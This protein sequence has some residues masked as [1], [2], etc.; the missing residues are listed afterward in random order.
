MEGR[1][2]EVSILSAPIVV[3]VPRRVARRMLFD[4]VVFPVHRGGEGRFSVEALIYLDHFHRND[5]PPLSSSTTASHR[6]G[7]SRAQRA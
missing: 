1:D 6:A 4:A 7:S 5:L 2:G 3:R